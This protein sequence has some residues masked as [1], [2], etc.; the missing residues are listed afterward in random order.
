MSYELIVCGA[1]IGRWECDW[2]TNLDRLRRFLFDFFFFF[3][4]E[5]DGDRDR[6]DAECDALSEPE[7]ESD[8]EC[9]RLDFLRRRDDED[10][11]SFLEFDSF[12]STSFV[13]LVGADSSF[14]FIATSVVMELDGSDSFGGV[15]FVS[16]LVSAS[17]LFAFFSTSADI[18]RR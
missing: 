11:R 17:W 5:R 10:L 7:Y 13:V 9:F 14:S 3:D 2:F 12:G 8:S 18:V 16:V 1:R 15:P 6:E 4:R